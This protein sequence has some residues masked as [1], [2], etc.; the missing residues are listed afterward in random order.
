MEPGACA[1]TVDIR[2]DGHYGSEQEK[3]N[4]KELRARHLVLWGKGC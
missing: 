2:L 1:V 3:G 4:H